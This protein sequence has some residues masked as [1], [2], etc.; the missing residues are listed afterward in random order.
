MKKD[1][2]GIWSLGI[3]LL[4][5]FSLCCQLLQ[6]AG[7]AHCLVA[8]AEQVDFSGIWSRRNGSEWNNFYVRPAACGGVG[9]N[10][11]YTVLYWK[12]DENPAEA[13]GFRREDMTDTW[14]V[15]EPMRGGTG[16]LLRVQGTSPQQTI[17]LQML[18]N[19]HLL[20]L[21]SADLEGIYTRRETGAW[22][23]WEN[24]YL[25]QL[26]R[27]VKQQRCSLIDF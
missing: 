11:R 20:L 19:N 8:E 4:L 22:S 21:G 1:I 18:D 12:T 7:G 24:W 6:M 13:D 2:V 16:I 9:T 10:T 3:G 26:K 17:C 5:V 25:I 23:C 15:M 14:A 27:W